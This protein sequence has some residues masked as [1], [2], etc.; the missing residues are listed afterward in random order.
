MNLRLVVLAVTSA[1]VF[2]IG[3]TASAATLYFNGFETDTSGW[4]GATK[5][6]SGTNGVTSATGSSHAV[7]APSSTAF[8]TFGG[9]N[10]GA[11]SGVGV[12]FQE[13][14]TSVDVYLDMSTTALN[15]TN[16]DFSSAISNTTG[17]HRRDFVFNA[18]FYNDATG[19]GASTNRF[20]VSASNNSQ[21]G[22]AFAKNPASD[23]FAIGTTGWYTFQHHFYDN[24]GVLAVEMSVLNSTD[25]LLHSWL[26]SDPTDVINSTVGGNRYGWFD[27]N[28]F[29]ALAFDNSELRTL[30]DDVPEPLSMALVG[31]GVLGTIVRLR[32]RK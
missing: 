30:S 26:L 17:N 22:S 27:Y 21:P 10:F 9:Y 12:P 2:G 32:R 4:T 11:G 23:P 25:A 14:F 31:L 7:A 16:F 13:Y 18:G 28:E 15:D 19:P 6:S 8:T 24:G 3:S 1:L 5:V 29:S 20:V